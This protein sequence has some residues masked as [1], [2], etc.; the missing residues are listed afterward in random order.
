MSHSFYAAIALVFVAVV[1]ACEAA[2]IWWSSR[3]GAVA[4]RLQSRID[5]V[6][7]AAGAVHEKLTILKTPVL[8]ESSRF[9]RVLGKLRITQS[10]VLFLQQ[11]GVG[12][13]VGRLVGTCIALPPAVFALLSIL[14]VSMGVSALAAISVAVLPLVW[15]QGRRA[16]RL[17]Q[18]ERQLP[19][20]CDMLARSLRAGHA[21]AAAIQMVG[22]EFAEP[23]GGEFRYTF[24]EIN[25][26]VSLNDALTNLARRMPIHDLRYFVIAVLVQREAGGNLAEL[27][28]SITM[29][30]RE[31]FK[32]FDKVRVLCAEGKLSAWVLVLLPFVTAGAMLV[33][34]PGFLEVLW[35]DPA[36]LRVVQVALVLMVI[37]VFWIRRTV[38]IRV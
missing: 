24:D 19:D 15:V 22:L 9:H 23:M 26:G 32:F 13:S 10:L 29:L 35:Q 27:L 2:W 21:F 30:V 16:R 17:R 5:A 36:G 14:R 18:F 34:N 1:L 12:W 38:R 37:G 25:Y 11:S 6:S 8:D 20:A 28:D 31:R 3:H 33:I 4:R 7:N